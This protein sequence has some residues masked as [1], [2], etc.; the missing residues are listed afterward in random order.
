MKKVHA[1]SAKDLELKALK[2][3]VK[4]LEHQAMVLEANHILVTRYIREQI[5]LDLEANPNKKV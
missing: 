2:Q 4:E 5:E 3:R 1:K